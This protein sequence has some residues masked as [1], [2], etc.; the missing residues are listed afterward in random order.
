MTMT[1]D[2]LF[3]G[4]SRLAREN[5]FSIRELVFSPT[6]ASCSHEIRHSYDVAY[7]QMPNITTNEFY[8]MEIPNRK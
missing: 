7:M 4:I 2:E 1:P 6:I 5:G 8:L 3:A